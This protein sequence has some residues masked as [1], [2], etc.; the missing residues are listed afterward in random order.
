LPVRHQYQS[1][2]GGENSKDG[3]DATVHSQPLHQEPVGDKEKT[4]A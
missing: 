2:H 4:D 1:N 3:D